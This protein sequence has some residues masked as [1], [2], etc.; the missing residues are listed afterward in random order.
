M[1]IMATTTPEGYTV[2][3]QVE[4]LQNKVTYLEQV[5]E[6]SRRIAREQAEEAEAS[7]SRVMEAHNERMNALRERWQADA[8]E[9]QARIDA[10]LETDQGKAYAEVQDMKRQVE[11]FEVLAER[12][13]ERA[14]QAE[15]EKARAL[16]SV[17]GGPIHPDDPRVQHIWEKAYRIATNAGFCQ[18]FDRIAEALGIPAQEVDYEGYVTVTYSGTVSLP[19]SG[20]A[21]RSEIEDGEIVHSNIDSSDIVGAIDSYDIEWTIEEIEVNP[22]E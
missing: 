2:P 20:R 18:E 6:D 21:L 7:R 8:D 19:I 17:E 16:A 14:T 10:I 4:A 5:L 12:Y 9:K 22:N 1:D 11:R 3:E 15:E 13:K